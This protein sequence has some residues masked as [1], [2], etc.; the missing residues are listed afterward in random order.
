M[1]DFINEFMWWV[2]VVDLSSGL[3]WWI[4]VVDRSGAFKWYEAGLQWVAT[5]YLYF[6]LMD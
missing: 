5:T 6:L 4:E 1:V 3:K 2:G